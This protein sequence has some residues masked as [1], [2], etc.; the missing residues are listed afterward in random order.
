MCPLGFRLRLCQAN[1]MNAESL[2]FIGSLAHHHGLAAWRCAGD[3]QIPTWLVFRTL[4]VAANSAG[5]L[6]GGGMTYSYNPEARV[7][8]SSPDCL[9]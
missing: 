4:A 6:E 1:R 2:R 7:S 8:G 9:M 5:S 3:W